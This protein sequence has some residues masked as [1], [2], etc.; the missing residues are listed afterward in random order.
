MTIG[1][2]YA[3]QVG[4]ALATYSFSSAVLQNLIATSGIPNPRLSEVVEFVRA[5]AERYMRNWAEYVPGN[6]L[7]NTLLFGWC[8]IDHELQAYQLIPRVESNLLVAAKR[9]NV[10]EPIPIGSGARDFARC[11]QNLRASGDLHGRSARLPMLAVESLVSNQVR[12]DVGGD[13]QI[14]FATSQGLRIMTRV[15]PIVPGKPQAFCSF[16]GID[17]EELGQVGLCRIGITGLA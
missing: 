2:M 7:F 12:E 8:N 4:P 6:A 1:Y 15:R 16:L 3:G 13:I 9:V 14:G 5:T 17:T 11:L 10:S